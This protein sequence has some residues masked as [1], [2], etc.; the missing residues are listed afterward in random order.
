M[1]ADSELD[2]LIGVDAH[3]DEH[4]LA[5]VAAP[6]GAVVARQAVA[7][8]GAGY[9][10]LNVPCTGSRSPKGASTHPRAPTW[11]ASRARARAAARR[12]AASNANSPAPSTPRSR[13]S[14]H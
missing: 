14:Q 9:R 2:Y 8:D 6:A 3:R 7:A 4:V 11:S 13:A 12:S 5:V 10:Q 1:L